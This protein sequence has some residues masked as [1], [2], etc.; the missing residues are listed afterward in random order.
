M[1]PVTASTGIEFFSADFIQVTV[2]LEPRR[3]D[4]A[5]GAASSSLNQ[6]FGLFGDLATGGIVG[7]VGADK[8]TGV[9]C[10]TARGLPVAALRCS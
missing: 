10:Q 4:R 2:S 9:Q 6:P 5:R 3:A 1:A 8:R 7:S